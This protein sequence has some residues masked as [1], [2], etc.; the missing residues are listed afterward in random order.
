MANVLAGLQCIDADDK[1]YG[2]IFGKEG[3]MAI[4]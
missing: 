4:Q 3:H 2:Q 1:L